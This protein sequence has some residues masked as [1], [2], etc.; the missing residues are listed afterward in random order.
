[1]INSIIQISPKQQVEKDLTGLVDRFAEKAEAA[2]TLALSVGM[3]WVTNENKV[4][5]EDGVQIAECHSV[6]AAN[7]IVLYSPEK[8]LGASESKGRIAQKILDSFIEERYDDLASSSFVAHIL[9]EEYRGLEAANM[10][11]EAVNKLKQK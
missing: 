6:T 7:V 10:F 9:I 3:T 1:M 4:I 2:R 5:N 11:S 8:I